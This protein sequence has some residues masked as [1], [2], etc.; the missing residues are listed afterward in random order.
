MTRTLSLVT[1][2]LAAG[3]V[4]AAYLSARLFWFAGGL[5]LLFVL[6]MIA[7]FRRWNWIHTPGLFL[8]FGLVAL[9]FYLDL[10]ASL[11]F[12]AAFLSLA[13]WDLAGFASRLELAGPEAESTDLRNRNILRLSLTLAAG[14][15]L[16]LLALSLQL[17]LPFNWAVVLALVATGGLGGLVHRLLR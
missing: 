11:L 5:F 15:A 4:T 3:L 9:G 12:P 2:L 10:N 17:Q 1:V 7:F 6:W 14:V 13:G 16:V 8:V